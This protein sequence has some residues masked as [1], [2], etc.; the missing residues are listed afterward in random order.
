VLI[1]FKSSAPYIDV[2]MRDVEEAL[3]LERSFLMELEVCLKWIMSLL[4]HLKS[5]PKYR[6]ICSLP[7]S[8]SSLFRSDSDSDSTLASEVDVS[9]QV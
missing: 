3:S 5:I 6:S 1:F 8:T 2:D 4:K 9:L 7:M